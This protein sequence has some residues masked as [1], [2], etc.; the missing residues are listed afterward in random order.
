MLA[1]YLP[2]VGTVVMQQGALIPTYSGNRE[3]TCIY[4]VLGI[5]NSSQQSKEAN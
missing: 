5:S 4:S 1:G 3:S 2:I